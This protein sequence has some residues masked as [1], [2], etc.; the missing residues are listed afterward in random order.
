MYRC[1]RLLGEKGTFQTGK[2]T[3]IVTGGDLMT[4]TGRKIA[5][6]VQW[7]LVKG[8]VGVQVIAMT[9]HVEGAL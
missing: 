8:T 7:T 6:E 1:H 3:L 2:K 4:G 9:T 5:T